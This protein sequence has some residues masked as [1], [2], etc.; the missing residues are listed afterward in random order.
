MIKKNHYRNKD[1]R[2]KFDK[3][4]IA[5]IID[6]DLI[7]TTTIDITHLIVLDI[8]QSTA[9]EI[10]QTTVIRIFQ[11]LQLETPRI[12]IK[13]LLKVLLIMEVQIIPTK[14]RP[15]KNSRAPLQSD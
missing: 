10:I 14:K 2:S 15:P 4:F 13:D 8:L 9:R 3:I 5:T 6:I 11:I 1:S 12:A 7:P